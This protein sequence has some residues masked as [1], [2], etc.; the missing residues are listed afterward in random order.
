MI[1]TRFGWKVSPD[2]VV[3]TIWLA[4]RLPVTLTVTGRSE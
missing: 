2:V 3:D 4:G 1:T